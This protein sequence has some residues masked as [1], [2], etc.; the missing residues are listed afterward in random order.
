MRTFADIQV[1]AMG[2][3]FSNF[4]IVGAQRTGSS[5]LAESLSF[6]PAIVCGWEWTQRVP[7]V[8]KLSVARRGL[9]GDFSALSPEDQEHMSREIIADTRWLGFR[10]LF[11]SSDKWLLHPRYSPALW[12]DRF[13]AHLRW[14]ARNPEIR[15]IHIVRRDNLAWLTSKYVAR[16]V[17]AYHGKSYPEGTKVVI[18]IVEAIKRVQSKHWV[19]SRLRSI[20]RSNPYLRVDYEDFA[21][22][23]AAVLRSCV[24]FLDCEYEQYQRG[25]RHLKK[26]SDR[27]A[28]DYVDNWDQL[29]SALKERSLVNMPPETIS[30]VR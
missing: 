9:A 27:P 20:K 30:S 3:I 5:A 10:R 29:I 21:S 4:L 11:R 12:A 15:I 2:R 18:P 16:K 28:S 13:E 26:Q 22:D 6:H 25:E 1:T 8:H 19:D 17:K 24:S 14:W 23:E 7:L